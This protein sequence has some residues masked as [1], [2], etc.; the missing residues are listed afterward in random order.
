MNSGIEQ[1]L[2]FRAPS[3]IGESGALENQDQK[4]EFPR[5]SGL[6]LGPH[7]W[8]SITKSLYVYFIFLFLS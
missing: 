1:M 4:E 8:G 3:L 5:N 2:T 6:Q 7:L